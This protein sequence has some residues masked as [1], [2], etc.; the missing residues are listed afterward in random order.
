MRLLQAP[1]TGASP[2]DSSQH[3]T[4]MALPYLTEGE[5][6]GFLQY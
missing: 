4:A 6:E 5:S 2:P 1:A 3:E